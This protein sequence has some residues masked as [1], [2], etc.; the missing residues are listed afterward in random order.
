MLTILGC[1]YIL[2]GQH[3]G[4]IHA[5]YCTVRLNFYCLVIYC[6]TANLNYSQ[7]WCIS[8][9]VSCAKARGLLDDGIKTG[10]TVCFPSYNRLERLHPEYGCLIIYG[11]I[12]LSYSQLWYISLVVSYVE[13]VSDVANRLHFDRDAYGSCI[14]VT[15]PPDWI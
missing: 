14:W 5:V 1:L 8:L 12:A 13:V 11:C 9:L 15:A 2:D 6:Y 7:P 3:E 4:L 10:I